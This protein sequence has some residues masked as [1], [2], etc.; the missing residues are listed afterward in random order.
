VVDI[1]EKVI[2]LKNKSTLFTL[3]TG[4]GILLSCFSMPISDLKTVL[5]AD[6]YL[7]YY[8]G[9]IISLIGSNILILTIIWQSLVYEYKDYSPMKKISIIAIIILLDVFAIYISY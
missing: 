9:E 7:K 2:R 1:I 6:L 4:I 3:L 5:P 8:R